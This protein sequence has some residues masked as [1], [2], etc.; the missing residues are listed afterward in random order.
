VALLALVALQVL[1]A[2]Q[3]S[4]SFIIELSGVACSPLLAPFFKSSVSR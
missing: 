2:L 4:S 1:V 3:K